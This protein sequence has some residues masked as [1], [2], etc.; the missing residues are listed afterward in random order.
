[1]KNVPPADVKPCDL[2]LI[3]A[4]EVMWVWWL[5]ISVSSIEN[6]VSNSLKP[7]K[8]KAYLL[9]NVRDSYI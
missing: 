1:M 3:E 9:Y 5:V 8:V 4:D 6:M 2:Q 7:Y